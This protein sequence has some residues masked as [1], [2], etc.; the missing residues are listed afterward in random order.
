MG[1]I[2]VIR[3][4][5]IYVDDVTPMRVEGL[6]PKSINRSLTYRRFRYTISLYRPKPHVIRTRLYDIT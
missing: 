4:F 5:I 6:K 3:R 1:L 2:D